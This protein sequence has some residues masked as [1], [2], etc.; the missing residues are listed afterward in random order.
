MQNVDDWRAHPIPT[1]TSLVPT[2]DMIIRS[3]ASSK[4][5]WIR[6][7][8]TIPFALHVD[9]N[10]EKLRT[11]YV[12]HKGKMTLFIQRDNFVMGSADND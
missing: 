10:A 2:Q 7:P 6:G 1:S 9:Q 8:I 5:R 3:A 4:P 12:N 11:K